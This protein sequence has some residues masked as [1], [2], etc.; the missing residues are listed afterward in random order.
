MWQRMATKIS[1]R[2]KE[3]ERMIQLLEGKKKKKIMDP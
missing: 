3:S 2:E 1:G